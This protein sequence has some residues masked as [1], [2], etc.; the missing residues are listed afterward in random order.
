VPEIP[1]LRRLMQEDHLEFKATLSG[2]VRSCL[3][4]GE[5]GEGG[6]N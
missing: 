5:G 4:R 1:F 3:K 6:E 2:L